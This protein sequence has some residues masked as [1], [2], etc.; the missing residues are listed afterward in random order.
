MISFEHNK[1]AAVDQVD[2]TK[3]FLMKGRSITICHS[4][5]KSVNRKSLSRCKHCTHDFCPGCAGA[6]RCESKPA[7]RINMRFW[8]RQP[9][10]TPAS[11]LALV[12]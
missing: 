11:K 12:R 2:E 7:F 10:P 1:D 6:C 8:K 4:C 9:L 5:L 3:L